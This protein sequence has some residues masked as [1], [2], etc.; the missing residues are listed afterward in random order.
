MTKDTTISEAARSARR[1]YY[2]RYRE[3]NRAS[4]NEYHR[5]WCMKNPDKVRAT[6]VKHWNKK[7]AILAGGAEE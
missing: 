4:I 3:R 2:R 6:L 5:Q 1:E 7:A